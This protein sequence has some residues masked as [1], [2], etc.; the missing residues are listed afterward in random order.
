MRHMDILIIKAR[1]QN[2]LTETR[3]LDLCNER[4]R[5]GKSLIIHQPFTS[6]C[7]ENVTDN[8]RSCVVDG[9]EEKNI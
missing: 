4:L 2:L 9:F 1:R 5:G 8:A 7:K 3:P 6:R